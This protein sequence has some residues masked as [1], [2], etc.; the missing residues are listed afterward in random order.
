M[1]EKPIDDFEAAVIEGNI[2]HENNACLNWQA[3]HA[4]T[5]SNA[6][7]HRI[8]QKPKR[9]DYRKVDG[10]VASVMAYWG[11]KHLPKKSSVYRRRGVLT[12]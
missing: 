4:A 11:T 2:R 6:R 7:G 8:I 12:A 3:G 1:M 9:G 5:H 10:M